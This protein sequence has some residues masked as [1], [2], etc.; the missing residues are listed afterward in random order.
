MIWDWIY[1]ITH[2]WSIREDAREF[3][4]MFAEWDRI[5]KR[6]DAKIAEAFTPEEWRAVRER[7][8]RKLS[9]SVIV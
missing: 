1:R 6:L 4:A 2:W 5:N 7:C 8:E 3:E 9:E